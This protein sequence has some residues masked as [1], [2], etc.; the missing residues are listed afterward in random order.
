MIQERKHPV[1][2]GKLHLLKY[3]DNPLGH[4]NHISLSHCHLHFNEKAHALNPNKHCCLLR[5]VAHLHK[6]ALR[7]LLNARCR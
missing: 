5:Q 3:N 1:L 4:C 7:A 2:S 6:R